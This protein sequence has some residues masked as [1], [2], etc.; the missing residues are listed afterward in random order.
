MFF[1]IVIGNFD[2]G[3]IS[4][5]FFSPVKQRNGH[6]SFCHNIVKWLKAYSSMIGIYVQ[7]TKF[8]IKKVS[9]ENLRINFRN[10]ALEAKEHS[11]MPKCKSN[12]QCQRKT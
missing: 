8:E 2:S 6:E 12:N 9:L 3:R 4:G 10:C 5:Y 11:V 7:I 1:M